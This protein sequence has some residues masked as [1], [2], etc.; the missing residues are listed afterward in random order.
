MTVSATAARAAWATLAAGVATTAMAAR[1]VSVGQSG[2]REVDGG[3]AVPA[4]NASELRATQV[5]VGQVGLTDVDEGAAVAAIGRELRATQIGVGEAGS[6]QPDRIRSYEC[7][8]VE[9]AIRQ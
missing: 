7:G 3:G 9:V 1:A 2:L 4:S 5:G 8:L 6:V